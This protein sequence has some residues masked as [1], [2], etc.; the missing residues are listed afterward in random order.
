MDLKDSIQQRANSKE[1][2]WKTTQKLPE[3][4]LG[5]TDKS[6]TYPFGLLIQLQP[7]SEGFILFITAPSFAPVLTS[8]KLMLLHLPQEITFQK[9]M[10]WYDYLVMVN[11]F[12]EYIN[13]SSIFCKVLLSYRQK[14]TF[15]W[16]SVVSG[17]LHGVEFH[18]LCICLFS[19]VSTP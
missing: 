10:N 7:K 18:Y 8:S 13:F 1:K 14:K 3:I 4:K 2:R 16:S 6:D 5:G 15:N 19:V 12:N 11:F 9:K 17:S